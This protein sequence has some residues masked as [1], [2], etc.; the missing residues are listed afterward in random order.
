[1]LFSIIATFTLISSINREEDDHSRPQVEI[2]TP[3][4]PPTVAASDAA[5]VAAP[6]TPPEVTPA[7]AWVERLQA[8]LSKTRVALLDNIGALFKTPAKLDNELLDRMHE[9]LYRADTG[10]R[11]AELLVAACRQQLQGEEVSFAAIKKV[12][13]EEATRLLAIP[14]STPLE[15]KKQAVLMVGVNGVGKTTTIGK[16]ARYYQDEQQK[17]LL[18][19][20]DTFRAAAIEQLQVWAERLGVDLVKHQQGADP[21]AVVFDAMQS[22]R[23]RDTDVLL[24]DTAGRLHSKDNLMAELQKIKKIAAKND[25]LFSLEVWLVLDATTGQ[26]ALQQVKAFRELVQVSGL[27]VTKL[28]GTAKGGVLLGI[29]EQ[30]KIPMRFIGVGEQA[31]DLRPFEAQEVA[32]SMFA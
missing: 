28:D 8:G 18:C 5:T 21:G 19:A 24:I 23:R 12:L 20:A 7:L 3:V 27:I 30:F 15:R 4:T 13:Q 9:M 25:D 17:V 10:N 14:T 11:V 1:M 31:T 2:E 22:A 29:C 6:P 32:N 26:N 16:L